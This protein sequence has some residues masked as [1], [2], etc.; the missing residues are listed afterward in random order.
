[1]DLHAISG[2]FIGALFLTLVLDLVGPLYMR[3]IRLSRARRHANRAW[4]GGRGAHGQVSRTLTTALPLAKASVT[5][6]YQVWVRSI[7]PSGQSRYPVRLGSYA[8]W[9]QVVWAA[10]N[11]RISAAAPGL[12]VAIGILGTFVGLVLGLP[13]SGQDVSQRQVY[14]LVA[15]LRLAFFSSIYGIAGSIIFS[16][17]EKH[18]NWG[19]D[20]AYE[21]LMKESEKWFPCLDEH[22]RAHEEDQELESLTATLQG[23]ATDIAAAIEDPLTKAID[24]ALSKSLGPALEQVATQ[25]EALDTTMNEK[26]ATSL[27]TVTTEFKDQLSESMREELSGLTSSIEVLVTTQDKLVENSAEFARQLEAQ[28]RNQ[29]ELVESIVDAGAA[30]DGVIGD[31]RASS[32][33]LR[34]LTTQAVEATSEITAAVMAASEAQE[35]LRAV[36]GEFQE[37][38]RRELEALTEI[39]EELSTAW[40][41]AAE[42]ARSAGAII[43]EKVESLTRMTDSSLTGALN[44]F[45]EAI[46]EAVERFSGTVL[47]VNSTVSELPAIL[48]RLEKS[49]TEA[50]ASLQAQHKAAEQLSAAIRDSVDARSAHLEQLLQRTDQAIDGSTEGLATAASS[51]Q[52]AA[53]A[54]EKMT[55]GGSATPLDGIPAALTQVRQVLERSQVQHGRALDTGNER[56]EKVHAVLAEL[57]RTTE[58]TY[59]TLT[60]LTSAAKESN[61]L[62][63]ALRS[64]P[65]A[66]SKRGLTGIFRRGR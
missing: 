55:G 12:L 51:L 66:D 13:D 63:E 3:W 11:R 36:M 19:L 6:F 61:T 9:D 5:T 25:V 24:N 52:E 32:E 40:G 29:K 65:D 21:R 64:D 4:N 26:I 8:T 27:N 50:A 56:M 45:D 23:L 30:L 34:A 48:G 2:L 58:K 60:S 28:S 59:D 41:G 18:A 42:T 10:S 31:L 62:L 46:A 54:V 35:K 1:M 49:A 53:R 39:R 16:F 47:E 14:E 17:L 37:A 57:S 22:E 15:G 44:K 7:G 20:R 43:S 38:T 33:S